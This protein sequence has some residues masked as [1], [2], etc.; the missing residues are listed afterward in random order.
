M[1]QNQQGLPSSPLLVKGGY[2][3]GVRIPGNE[4]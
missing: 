4:I 3:G 1:L 2:G